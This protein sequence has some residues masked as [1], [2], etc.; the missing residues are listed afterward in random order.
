MDWGEILT[1]IILSVVGVL[2]SGLGV[3]VTY[4][5]N[6]HIKNEQLK[7]I[8][9]SLKDLIQ[10]SVL[11]V[12]QTY[13]DALKKAGSFDLEAQKQALERCL[14]NIKVNMPS[15]VENWLKANYTDVESYLKSLVEAQIG[16][17]KNNAK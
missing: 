10:H 7:R 12:Q 16:Y 5:I 1:N 8:V 15:D 3:Y 11:E 14:N 2:I 6:K 9:N 4:L 13:V 17:L